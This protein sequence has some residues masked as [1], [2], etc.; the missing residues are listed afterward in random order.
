[1]KRAKQKESVMKQIVLASGAW[2][3]LMVYGDAVAA[4]HPEAM[5]G[6]HEAERFTK[7]MLDRLEWRDADPEALSYWEA[8]AWLGGDI[9]K[10]W[11]K[12]EGEVAK[13]DT[14]EASLEA[15]YSRAVAP[16]W[17][18]QLGARHDFALQGEPARN[19]IAIGVKG[20]APYKFEIDATLYAG[21]QGRSALVTQVEYD[22][23][24]TQRLV[25]MPELEAALYGKEDVARGIGS[26]LAHL[27]AGLRLRYELRREFAPYVGVNWTG[28]YGDTADL[29]RGHGAPVRDTQWLIGVRAWW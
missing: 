8:Q 28:K 9:H 14:E 12:S 7:V 3:A 2:C 20:L 1:M 19:W 11:L 15:Y 29:A 22:L 5:Q 13:G 4:D 26:G 23:L 6:M 10:L 21:A 18:L 24:I 25:L 27:A 17:D 16:Y